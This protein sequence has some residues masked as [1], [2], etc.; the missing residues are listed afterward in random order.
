MSAN[1]AQWSIA[2]MQIVV[3]Q[4]YIPYNITQR[5]RHCNSINSKVAVK[6]EYNTKVEPYNADYNSNTQQ[7]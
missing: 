4:K 7:S 3:Q 5:L 6:V 1:N 2:N